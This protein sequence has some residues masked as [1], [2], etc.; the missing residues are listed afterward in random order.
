[1]SRPGLWNTFQTRNVERS[2]HERIGVEVL[3]PGHVGEVDLFE[4]A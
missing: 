4:T 1:M 2:V 3:R